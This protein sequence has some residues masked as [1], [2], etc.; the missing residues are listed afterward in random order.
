MFAKLLKHEMK[1]VGG[2]LGILSLAALAVGVLGGLLFRIAANLP[3]AYENYAAILIIT[4]PFILISLFAYAFGGEI[5]LVF[6]FYKR[7]FTDEGYLT[8]T[9]PV[10]VWQIYLSS[11]LNMMFWM[12][13]IVVVTIL[14]FL[15]IPVIALAGTMEWMELMSAEM[16]LSLIFGEIFP[17]VSAWMFISPVISFVSSSVLMITS[18]TLGCVLAKRHKILASIGCYYAVSAVIGTISSVISTVSMIT[19]SP[20][21]VFNRMY[22]TTSMIQLVIA[23]SGSLLSIWLMDKKLNLP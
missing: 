4:L 5:Y 17:Q 16:E 12:V 6:Q 13:I 18:T 10:P 2:L 20:Q 22:M 9:L 21:M 7:K 1:T 11:L 15:L 3:E 23:V 14:S 19:A 8:F